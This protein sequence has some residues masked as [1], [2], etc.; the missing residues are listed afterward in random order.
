MDGLWQVLC[1]DCLALLGNLLD[2]HQPPGLG[3]TLLGQPGAP[4]PRV[5]LVWDFMHTAVKCP[6][7]LQL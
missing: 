5:L 3:S 4:I 1:Q 6:V 7:L 2:H